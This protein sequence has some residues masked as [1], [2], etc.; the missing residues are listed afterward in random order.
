MTRIITDHYADGSSNTRRE[1]QSTREEEEVNGYGGAQR[2]MPVQNTPQ[3]VVQT[4]PYQGQGQGQPQYQPVAPPPQRFGS[5]SMPSQQQSYVPQG[6]S[7]DEVSLGQG[8]SS[9][10]FQQ[11]SVRVF[12][13]KTLI[14]GCKHD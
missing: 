3:F 9:G 12:A 14:Y 2:S 7:Y 11:P 8:S 6:R 13:K 1:M 4:Q 10:Q 5:G